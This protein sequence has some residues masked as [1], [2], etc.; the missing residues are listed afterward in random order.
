MKK[1]TTWVVTKETAETIR[2]PLNWL[3]EQHPHKPVRVDAANLLRKIR[4]EGDTKQLVLTKREKET[5]SA[6]YQAF[7]EACTPPRQL[8]F[9]IPEGRPTMDYRNRVDRQAI[10]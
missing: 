3:K 1:L 4:F 10:G 2:G 8:K 9:E 5:L 7:P 6:L